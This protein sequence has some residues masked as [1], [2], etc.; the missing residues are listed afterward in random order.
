LV[1]RENASHN[2]IIANIQRFDIHLTDTNDLSN[3]SR[4]SKYPEG[5]APKAPYVSYG[6][7]RLPLFGHRHNSP[8]PII[9]DHSTL[10]DD[11]AVFQRYMVQDCRLE[12]NS[13]LSLLFVTLVNSECTFDFGMSCSFISY[14]L[15]QIPSSS[16]VS[17]CQARGGARWCSRGLAP[18]MLGKVVL[19]SRPLPD[20][21]QHSLREDLC[22]HSE[23]DH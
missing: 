16:M 7:S 18:R 2:I 23:R 3:T 22:G 13:R 19:Y 6:N 5:K 14:H 21:L 11:N 4:K 9:Q 12:S 17:V 15:N 1:K 10:L 8:E 20:G